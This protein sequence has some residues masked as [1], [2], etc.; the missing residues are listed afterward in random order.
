MFAGGVSLNGIIVHVKR[1]GRLL[2]ALSTGTSGRDISVVLS[3]LEKRNVIFLWSSNPFYSGEARLLK[4]IIIKLLFSATETTGPAENNSSTS[5][6]DVWLVMFLLFL[7][8]QCHICAENGCRQS[9]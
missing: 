6:G 5:E 2:A 9:V 3:L 1:Q 8:K 7:F 4:D